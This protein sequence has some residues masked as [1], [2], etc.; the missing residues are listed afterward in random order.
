MQHGREGKVYTCAQAC[1]FVSFY[2]IFYLKI[3]LSIVNL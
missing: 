2:S 1:V 3:F